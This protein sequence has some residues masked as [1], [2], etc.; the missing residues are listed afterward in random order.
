M[1]GKTKEHKGYVESKQLTTLP[2]NEY[3]KEALDALKKG[4]FLTVQYAGENNVMTIG[5]GQIGFIWGKPIMTVLVRKSRYTKNMIDGAQEFSVSI[6]FGEEMRSALA[7]CGS[8]SGKDIDKIKELKL[9]LFESEKINS[10]CIKCKGIHFEC[11]V[12]YKTDMTPKNLDD[13]TNYT[14]YNEGNYHTIY[15]A[16]IVN[17][18]EVP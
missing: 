5:W 13:I 4:A 8:K 14:W 6:P 9:E 16:E 12:L 11:M 18:V 15:F 3:A 10:P 17:T 7:F 1:K 2:Y